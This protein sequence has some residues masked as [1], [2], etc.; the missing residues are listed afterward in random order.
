MVRAGKRRSSA[1]R[2]SLRSYAS[3]TRAQ[4]TDVG[5][6]TSGC[7]FRCCS[8]FEARTPR[9]ASGMWRGYTL[10]GYRRDTKGSSGRTS[11]IRRVRLVITPTSL[12]RD[13]KDLQ[14]RVQLLYRIHADRCIVYPAWL[15]GNYHG[16]YLLDDIKILISL[17]ADVDEA[18]AWVG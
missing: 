14:E 12:T 9:R 1:A 17:I 3:L 7:H 13:R 16:N 10:H 2:A 5:T 11:R 8:R 15:H 4:Q 18:P 6:R